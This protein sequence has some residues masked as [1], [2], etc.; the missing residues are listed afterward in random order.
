[1]ETLIGGKGVA[2]GAKATLIQVSSGAV[3]FGQ[4]GKKWGIRERRSS[5]CCRN[6]GKV[7]PDDLLGEEVHTEQKTAKWT[8]MRARESKGLRF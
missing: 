6:N 5:K 4:G 3:S 1:V 2:K 7:R 8:V